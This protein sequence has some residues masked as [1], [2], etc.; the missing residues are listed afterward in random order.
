MAPIHLQ[1][2][3]ARRYPHGLVY[4]VEVLLLRSCVFLLKALLFNSTRTQ[5]VSKTNILPSL[6]KLLWS[7]SCHRSTSVPFCKKGMGR[8][9][10]QGAVLWLVCSRDRPDW[11]GKKIKKRQ[12]HR[13]SGVECTSL[14]DEE[15]TVLGK[16]SVLYYI[17]LNEEVELLHTGK[18]GGWV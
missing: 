9:P 5:E 7:I 6:N 11:S 16:L 12:T 17:Q 1:S 3:K 8:L 10:C 15:T 13:E 4:P 14:L 2:G 18:Q